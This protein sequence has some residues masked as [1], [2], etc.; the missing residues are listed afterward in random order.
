[1]NCLLLTNCYATSSD[2]CR[3]KQIIRGGRARWRALL[4]RAER[5]FPRREIIRQFEVGEL[6]GADDQ[7]EAGCLQRIVPPCLEILGEPGAD[8]LER[9]IS[10]FLGPIPIV[11]QV[12]LQRPERAGRL[13]TLVGE[14]EVHHDEHALWRVAVLGPGGLVQRPAAGGDDQA[15]H[16]Q[17]LTERA[18]DRRPEVVT[19][20]VKTASDFIAGARGRVEP[21]RCSFL[22]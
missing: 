8:I 6:I 3:A 20:P 1:M 7:P 22:V 17:W 19:E 16:L 13:L 18:R 9:D 2:S 10:R 4:D 14:R 15:T 21:Q 5:Y 11:E 12:Q